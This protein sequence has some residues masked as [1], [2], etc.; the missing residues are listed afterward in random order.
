MRRTPSS[1]SNSTDKSNREHLNS[2]RSCSSGPRVFDTAMCATAKRAGATCT[3][4]V[5]GMTALAP[6][7]WISWHYPTRLLR[8]KELRCVMLRNSRRFRIEECAY[9]CLPSPMAHHGTIAWRKN[10]ECAPIGIKRL[11]TFFTKCQ[12]VTERGLRLTPQ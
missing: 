6:T 4:A 1:L 5:Q 3:G 10:I 8:Y 9:Q 2:N 7:C 11:L 12:F